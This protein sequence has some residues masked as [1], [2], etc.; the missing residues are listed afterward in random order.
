MRKRGFTLI[1]LLVVIA[2]I[3]VLIALLLPAVQQ[4]REAARRSQ[5]KN[6]IKQIGL[7]LHN[8]H[9]AMTVFPTGA[10]GKAMGLAFIL[11]YL[12]QSP[13]YNLI[14]FNIDIY[15]PASQPAINTV[16]PVFVCPSNPTS[17]VG[18]TVS[19]GAWYG[20]IAMVD[21]ALVCGSDLGPNT[22]PLAGGALACNGVFCYTTK[23][24]TLAKI[25]MKDITDGSSNTFGVGEYAG[26]N[27]GQT[28]SV[29]GND[30]IPGVWVRMG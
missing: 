16:I 6:N 27:I 11:P 20:S 30:G 22:S 14:N 9:D 1:E 24:G 12:D 17:A 8:Y 23:W 2:I 15:G 7:A 28:G 25:G 4:A 5:C 13:L 10:T 3:A 19:G 29:R 26:L 18:Y 21:Y